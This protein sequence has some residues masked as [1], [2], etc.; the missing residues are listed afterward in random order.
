[1]IDQVGHSRHITRVRRGLRLGLN[2]LPLARP[3]RR[4]QGA[5]SRVT[6]DTESEDEH[7]D[8][9]DERRPGASRA[10]RVGGSFFACARSPPRPP[11]V[12]LV[13]DGRVFAQGSRPKVRDDLFGINGLAR[14]DVF[15]G[16]GENWGR[17]RCHGGGDFVVAELRQDLVHLEERRDAAQALT[18]SLHAGAVHAPPGR[19][20]PLAD[21]VDEIDDDRSALR[22]HHDVCGREVAVD[23]TRR[24]KG[25]QASG[26][27]L[28]DLA[29]GCLGAQVRRSDLDI[30]RPTVDV[31][32]DDGPPTVVGL[33]DVTQR[34]DVMRR[35]ARPRL[36][37]RETAA[38][39]V[40]GAQGDERLPSVRSCS[41]Q[42]ATGTDVEHLTNV[43]SPDIHTAIV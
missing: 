31:V 21:L 8:S 7:R 25:A 9:T 28:D 30:Q 14:N 35:H 34:D 39:I 37:P 23:D 3:R 41:P 18:I 11:R 33:D 20:L 17:P 38:P 4:G 40:C 22:R 15:L 13:F 12:S 27:S 24:V 26:N 16:V 6:A 10:F 19:P 1:M 29:S 5:P 32:I 42:R 43:I 2:A 36:P